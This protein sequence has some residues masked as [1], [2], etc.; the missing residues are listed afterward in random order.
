[1]ARGINENDVHGAADALVHAGEKPTVERIR[2]HLGTG[3]PNTVTRWLDTWWGQLGG[4]LNA[5]QRSLDLPAAPPEVTTL[6]S[7][8]WEHA[9]STAM[10]LAHQALASEVA[11]LQ[12]ERE[13]LAAADQTRQA[14]LDQAQA[15]L[16][17][18]MQARHTADRRTGDLQRL[19][20]HLREQL[21][22]LTR[23]RDQATE[24]MSER[25]AD[26]HA[27]VLRMQTREAEWAAERL[28]LTEH[29]RA[30]EDRAHAEVDRS[31]QDA[32]ALKKQV[33]EA[34]RERQA[35]AEAYQVREIAL[36]KELADAQR[37]A[38][39]A[40]A[41]AE[42]TK[43]ERAAA[44]TTKS[45]GAKRRRTAAKPPKKARPPKTQA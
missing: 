40:L 10:G 33:D 23:Q 5:Q 20:D 15:T 37:E 41:Q 34:Q 30:A 7:Q 42:A 14:A 24:R 26:A 31:R 38:A 6:A 28:R 17:D 9:L 16:R 36:R 45:A 39:V 18:A 19:C 12:A 35:L 3:S 1:M 22:D 32:R 4:R 2:A 21:S 11:S 29:L 44:G 13:A 43:A 27:A 8:W 25:E